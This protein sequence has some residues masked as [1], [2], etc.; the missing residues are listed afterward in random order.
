MPTHNRVSAD[1]LLADLQHVAEKLGHA[2]SRSEYVEHG[3]HSHS[4]QAERFGTWNA[5]KR[6][7]GLGTVPQ[8][9]KHYSRKELLLD[10]QRVAEA[11]DGNPSIGDYRE[12]GSY[13]VAPYKNRFGS[14]ADAKAAAG[15]ERSAPLAVTEDQLLADL[16]RVADKLGYSPSQR[17][18][19][20]HGT[21]SSHTIKERF[22]LWNEA[23]KAAGLST[24][25][26]RRLSLEGMNPEDLGLSPIGDRPAP[27]DD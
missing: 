25:T 16:K 6:Q 7:A 14:W 5:A 23:K 10:L 26:T 1:E 15:F 12:H 9:G 18:Y 27:G 8:S 21:H 3:E 20:K 19:D 22:D 17:E 13:S 24:R 4:T 2:P 11:V